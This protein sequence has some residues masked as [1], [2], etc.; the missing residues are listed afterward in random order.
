MNQPMGDEGGYSSREKKSINCLVLLPVIKQDF[1]MN[2]KHCFSFTICSQFFTLLTTM[3]W[4]FILRDVLTCEMLR[5]GIAA[6]LL[7]KRQFRAGKALDRVH[8]GQEGDWGGN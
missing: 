6:Q 1:S 8:A 5:N 7:Q 4:A 2:T 3:V